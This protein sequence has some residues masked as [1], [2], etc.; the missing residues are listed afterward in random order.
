MTASKKLV[1]MSRYEYP[2]SHPV[3]ENVFAK[4]IAKNI[5]IDFI[6]KGKNNGKNI[7]RWHN[8]R[9]ILSRE[10]IKNKLFRGLQKIVDYQAIKKLFNII[11]R[12]RIDFL[13]IRDMPIE[14][15]I[16]SIFKK[17]YNFEILYQFSAPLGE[18]NIAYSKMVKGYFRKCWY[19]ISGLLFNFFLT[20]A[21][22]KSSKILPISEKHKK[23][24]K[25][26]VD[27]KKMHPLTMGVDEQ[28]ANKTTQRIIFLENLKREN[29]IIVYFGTLIENRNPKFILDIFKEVKK[30]IENCK[31]LLIGMAKEAEIKELKRNAEINGIINDVIFTGRLDKNT[32][33]NYLAYCDLSLCIIPPTNY[34]EMSSP[35]K[36]YESLGIGVPVVANIEIA[37]NRK[38]IEESQGGI[39]QKY[40]KDKLCIAIKK[41]LKNNELREK[42]KSNGKK[43]ILK[44]YTYKEIAN[45]IKHL[46]LTEIC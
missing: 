44:N 3:L 14:T 6:L 13:L 40:D 27:S 30:D 42:M 32:L 11:G 34:F 15:C 24:L 43:Y 26:S 39:I 20:L 8:A 5:D 19:R 36:L 33:R 12:K 1:I 37:E 28:W 38:I 35:T 4:E 45:G 10:H 2:C 46:F 9:I 22:R 16:I 41:I 21:I 18:L 17:K 7:I 31:L 23:N 29:Y 25:T